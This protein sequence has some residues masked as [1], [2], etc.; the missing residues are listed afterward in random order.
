MFTTVGV[1]A[2]VCQ[3]QPLYRLSSDDMRLDNLIQISQGYAAV[4]HG[5][6]INHQIRAVLAL[7]E[8]TGLVGPDLPF[9]PSLGQLLFESLLQLRAGLGIAA[10]T[11]MACRPLVATN[12]DVFLKLGHE[13]TVP[14]F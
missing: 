12:K 4:P 13:E 1:E 5:V 7:V 3:H 11:G 8:T 2:G 6:R 14:D 10:T 9:Q